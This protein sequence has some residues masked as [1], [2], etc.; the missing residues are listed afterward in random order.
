MDIRKIAYQRYQLAWMLTHGITV[1]DIYKACA[2][3]ANENIEDKGPNATFKADDFRD[4]LE[5]HGF[6]SGSLWVCFDEFMGCEYQDKSYMR[7]IL[8]YSGGSE[9]LY[10]AYLRDI[11]EEVVPWIDAVKLLNEAVDAGVLLKDPETG[12][13]VVV[14]VEGDEEIRK[15][16]S[17]ET[18][19]LELR[20]DQEGR[21][22]IR[23]AIAEKANTTTE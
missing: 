13:I 15:E 16:Q 11:G 3:A 21:A 8:Q 20:F 6:G 2:E 18:L 7:S 22:F 12:K 5:E 14:F 10:A 19:A 9:D 1:Q 17:I 23:N 4:Y